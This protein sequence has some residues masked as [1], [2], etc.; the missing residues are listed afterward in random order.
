MTIKKYTLEQM[1]TLSKNHGGSVASIKY[2]SKEMLFK[3]KRGHHFKRKPCNVVQG[4]WCTI[5][6][7]YKKDID[8]MRSF[9]KK[10]S[11]ELLSQTYISSMEHLLWKCSKKHVIKSS[12]NTL[13]TRVKHNKN[14]CLQCERSIKISTNIDQDERERNSAYPNIWP[15]T[16]NL[17]ANYI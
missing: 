17:L 13:S 1:R 12:Y 16:Q 5:C 14:W 2:S 6:S 11:G 15:A 4:D 7:G 10:N 9:A 3:C 8:A